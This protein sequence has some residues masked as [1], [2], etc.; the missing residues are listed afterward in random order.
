MFETKE[1][2]LDP[3]RICIRY[4]K[5]FW[6]FDF[7][8]SIP[9]LIHILDAFGVPRH[10]LVIYAMSAARLFRYARL[11]T[12]LK[13][14]R[15]ITDTMKVKKMTHDIFR[16]I[17]MTFFLVHWWTCF[18]FIVPKFRYKLMHD[19]PINSWIVQANI[20]PNYHSNSLIIY[21]NALVMTSSHFYSAGTGS[22]AVR[23]ATEQFLFIILYMSGVIYF[24]YILAM[25]LELMNSASV[26]ESQYEHILCEL[27]E[28]TAAK[29]VRPKLRERLVSYYESKFQKHYFRE[30]AIL[31]TLSEHFREELSLFC[32]TRLL[33]KVG[34][35]QG[36]SQFIINDVTSHLK[37]DMFLQNDVVYLTGAP[38]Q[39]M[40]FIAH[41]TVAVFRPNG[42]E[43]CHYQDGEH[44]GEGSIILET[45]NSNR[46][47]NCVAI[48]TTECLRLEKKDL[49]RLMST[50]P[51]FKQR[52]YTIAI[53]KYQQFNELVKI[54][55]DDT[56]STGTTQHDVLMD[57]QHDKV[58]RP[59]RR[60]IPFTASKAENVFPTFGVP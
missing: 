36:L 40:F 21:I 60:R 30:Q 2:V 14:L 3:K 47:N 43:I 54:A 7:L 4:L 12:M 42:K 15:R 46:T 50:Y 39:C 8:G 37:P 23:D 9:I 26:S 57:L 38:A 35:F 56:L 16:L 10:K 1:I 41:G 5:S 27:R 59:S 53:E 31:M 18:V 29:Q 52:M 22:H 44:F 19:L 34:I 49:S 20:L 17:L 32:T 58:L 45:M 6:I 33:E 48:E 28:Y 55:D 24:A 51:D 11:C 25:V 13:Y